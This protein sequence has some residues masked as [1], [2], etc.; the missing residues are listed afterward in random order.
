M[1]PDTTLPRA[2]RPDLIGSTT[3]TD[4]APLTE[5]PAPPPYLSAAAVEV[6]ATTGPP[7]I[8]AGLLSD[9]DLDCLARYCSV[10]SQSRATPDNAA[11]VLLAHK[12][13]TTLGIAGAQSKLRTKPLKGLSQGALKTPK[14]DFDDILERLYAKDTE[15]PVDRAAK[16]LEIWNAPRKPNG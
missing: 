15:P 4:F 12:L 3:Q 13:G 10:E 6:W 1:A 2:N 11:L 9:T 14:S 5:L 7:M 16:T 8:V